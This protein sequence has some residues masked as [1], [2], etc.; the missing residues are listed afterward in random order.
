MDHWI[1]HNRSVLI[2]TADSKCVLM[3]RQVCLSTPVNDSKHIALWLRITLEHHNR[4]FGWDW[5]LQHRDHAATSWLTCIRA[6]Q[7]SPETRAGQSCDQSVRLLECRM[8]S[9]PLQLWLLCTTAQVKWEHLQ[10]GKQKVWC[11]LIENETVTVL[12]WGVKICP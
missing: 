2:E 8:L 12:R 6:F 9:A 1:L 4:V 10:R 7:K 5:A 3:L 11:F